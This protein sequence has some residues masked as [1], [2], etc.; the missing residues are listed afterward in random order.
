MIKNKTNVNLPLFFSYF[1]MF[2]VVMEYR[3]YECALTQI[4]HDVMMWEK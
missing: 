3:H 4:I 2:I 1:L